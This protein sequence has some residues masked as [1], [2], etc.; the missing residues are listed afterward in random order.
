MCRR[1]LRRTTVS[2]HGERAYRSP[3]KSAVNKASAGQPPAD[4]PTQGQYAIRLINALGIASALPPN[5]T[6]QDAMDFLARLGIA[7]A[8]G[9]C[10]CFQGP[11]CQCGGTWSQDEIIRLEDLLC[12][13]GVDPCDPNAPVAISLDELIEQILAKYSE[14]FWIQTR[15][16][17]TVSPF[18]P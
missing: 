14:L 4:A 5:A 10:D 8:E 3:S 18:A 9:P 7:P 17:L 6:V 2:A 16:K 1:P 11:R 13:A 15:K 12:I